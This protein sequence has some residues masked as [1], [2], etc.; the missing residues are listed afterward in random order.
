MPPEYNVCEWR[1]S[2]PKI[3]ISVCKKYIKQGITACKKCEV[4]KEIEDE[5]DN[6]RCT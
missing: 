2:K 5:L 4:R 3:H 6:S 1:I